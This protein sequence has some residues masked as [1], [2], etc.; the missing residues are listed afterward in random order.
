MLCFFIWV[1]AAACENSQGCTFMTLRAL[2]VRHTST[3]CIQKAIAFIYTNKTR[4]VADRMKENASLVRA[5]NR[6]FLGKNETNL[7]VA[8][9]SSEAHVQVLR[10]AHLLQAALR[11]PPCPSSLGYMH[12]GSSHRATTVTDALPDPQ[13]PNPQPRPTTRYAFPKCECNGSAGSPGFKCG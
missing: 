3:K 7:P 12:T 6:N 10:A 1:L 8:P 11:R 2:Q 4:L 13:G 9:Y 5:K